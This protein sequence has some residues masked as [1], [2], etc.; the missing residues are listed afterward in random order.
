MTGN[1]EKPGFKKTELG[2]IPEEWEIIRLE[3]IANTVK[4]SFAP[5]NEETLP[6]I[7]L[8]HIQQNTLQLSAI[9]NSE[10]VTSTKFK[11]TCGDILFGKLRPY[12]RKVVI[13]DF[14][15]VSW[16]N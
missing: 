3:D 7:G 10:E 11:F 8:E 16:K 4:D 14:E 6:Y 1:K 5:N 9:G 15:G 12:F 13:P 2:W